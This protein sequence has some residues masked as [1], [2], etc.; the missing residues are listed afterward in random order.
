MNPG[1]PTITHDAFRPHFNLAAFRRPLP[2]NGQGNLGNAV[3]GQLR[4]PGWQNWDFTLA[5]RIPVNIGRGGSVRVQAQFYNVFN[6]VQFQRLA[7]SY[8]FA[9][10]GNTNTTT[11]Q[12]DQAINPF[13]FGITIRMDYSG[14]DPVTSH[15]P[16][17]HIGGPGV[18]LC[19][20]CRSA[21]IY[22]ASGLRFD[23]PG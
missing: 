14:P 23:A 3:Q 11:G 5:R 17:A 20:A 10:S 16:R 2:V 8:T 21:I 4:H 9:A 1:D 7:A 19:T 6:L 13:N 15:T 12:Y 22:A 18:F